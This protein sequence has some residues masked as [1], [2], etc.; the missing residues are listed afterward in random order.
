[1]T[2]QDY[3][4]ASKKLERFNREAKLFIAFNGSEIAMLVYKQTLRRIEDA[5]YDQIWFGY[6]L[7]E[8]KP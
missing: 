7:I 5:M 6:A 8:I 3:I 2:K 4:N 1:M